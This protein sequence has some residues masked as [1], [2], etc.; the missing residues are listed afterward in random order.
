MARTLIPIVALIINQ[1][2]FSPGV[3]GVLVLN[4]VFVTLFIASGVLFQRAA[5]QQ[6]GSGT[7][8]RPGL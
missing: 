7:E 8:A 5:R 4:S 2:D 1:P 3:L 6:N